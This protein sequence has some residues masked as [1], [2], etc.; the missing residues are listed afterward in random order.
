MQYNVFIRNDKLIV[1]QRGSETGVVNLDEMPGNWIASLPTIEREIIRTISP[2]NIDAVEPDITAGYRPR[3]FIDGGDDE[4]NNEQ[5]TYEGLTTPAGEV[6]S[7]PSVIYRQNA[8]G[9]TTTIHYYYQWTGSNYVLKEEWEETR[10]A[11]GNFISS[12]HTYHE[13]L[14]GGWRNSISVAQDEDGNT[15]GVGSTGARTRPGDMAT[16]A[17]SDQVKLA[18][19]GRWKGVKNAMPGGTA[20]VDTDFPIDDISAL[21]ALRELYWMNQRIKETVTIDLCPPVSYSVPAYQHVIDFTD[22]VIY[23][24]NVYF[25]SANNVSFTPTGH[26]QSLRLVRWF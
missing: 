4:Y 3:V 11:E 12:T 1:M 23:G 5:V 19:G 16:S 18:R 17:Y 8:D 14:Q 10:D 21:S 9:S 6:D 7:R 20:L 24:G 25:L 15:I 22:K 26:R 13:I 2:K